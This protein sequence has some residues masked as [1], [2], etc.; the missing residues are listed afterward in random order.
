MQ[1]YLRWI[2]RPSLMCLLLLGVSACGSN[3]A[4][5]TPVT[6]HLGITGTVIKIENFSS[7]LI[8]PRHLEIWLPPSYETK[9]AQHYP[10]LYM[11]DGQNIFDP[12]QSQYTKTDW[13]IDEAMTRLI[14][15][16]RVRETIVVGNWSTENRF[17]EYMP[18]K[19]VTQETLPLYR[20]E[21]PE[22]SNDGIVSDD[23]LKFLVSELKP[24]IDQSYRTLP[25]RDDT[26]VM[27]S[28]MGGL[29]SLYAISEYP[30]VFGGAG[31]VST[32]FPYGDGALVEY[33]KDKLPD[34]QTNKI[35]FDYGTETLDH[36][37][38]GYQKR[39]DAY[40]YAAGFVEGEN[41]MS[42]KFQGHEHSEKAWRARVH[43][44]LMF[45]LGNVD[46]QSLN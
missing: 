8:P 21:Y 12:T 27:G 25:G 6:G 18:Q 31:C 16:G 23:Y 29:I 4:P 5:E 46:P 36:N 15:E 37:Y 40:G 45:L 10:I 13:G 22:F 41:W 7:E 32:H 14:A 26:F 24:Y 35:Y 44:P 33:F 9:T 11:H 19:A 3:S 17:N 43:I 30:D 20:K 28:S 1:Q 42:R 2:R 38:E 39:M 34:P